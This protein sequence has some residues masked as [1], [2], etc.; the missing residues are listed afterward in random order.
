MDL[1]TIVQLG[2]VAGQPSVRISL[3]TLVRIGDRVRLGFKLRRQNG[4][5]TEILDA[6]GDWRVVGVHVDASG[7]YA[8]QLIT[9]ESAKTAPIWR[10]IKKTSGWERSLPPARA[11][12]TVVA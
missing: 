11:P 1:A 4:G 6:S 7:P 2:D 3:P 5:R 9:L 8:K 12:R 10:A